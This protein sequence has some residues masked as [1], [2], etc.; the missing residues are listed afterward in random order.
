MRQEQQG[1]R[2]WVRNNKNTTSK[3]TPLVHHPSEPCTWEQNIQ[4]ASEV[5]I[6]TE[7]ADQKRDW[8]VGQY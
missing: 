1:T 3:V 7:L 6:L 8:S 5:S 4:P 2:K